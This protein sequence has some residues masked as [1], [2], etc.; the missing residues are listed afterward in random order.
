MEGRKQ[1]R[2]CWSWKDCFSIKLPWIASAKEQVGEKAPASKARADAPCRI[3][4]VWNVTPQGF[5]SWWVL[6]TFWKQSL[7]P[8]MLFLWLHTWII[9]KHYFTTQCHCHANTGNASLWM[10]Y[11]LCELK[12]DITVYELHRSIANL[13]LF[14]NVSVL[15]RCF[16]FY[17]DFL[18]FLMFTMVPVWFNLFFQNFCTKVKCCFKITIK[19]QWWLI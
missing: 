5:L 19:S 7:N 9:C 14:C 4:F 16:H 1:K 11:W 6:I 15:W 8:V 13:F 17:L 3:K 18:L 2:F 10:V 12:K